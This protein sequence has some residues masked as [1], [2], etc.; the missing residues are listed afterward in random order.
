MKFGNK[1]GFIQKLCVF[2]VHTTI[3]WLCLSCRN[4]LFCLGKPICLFDPDA[5]EH[6][7]VVQGRNG[8]FFSSLVVVLKLPQPG[9]HTAPLR[10][11]GVQW[12]WP[13]GRSSHPLVTRWHL[14]VPHS[15]CGNSF[16]QVPIWTCRRAAPAGITRIEGEGSSRRPEG[17]NCP[18]QAFL[19]LPSQ[20]AGALPAHTDLCF[21]TGYRFV[22]VLLVSTEVASGIGCLRNPSMCH[23]VHR[24]PNGCAGSHMPILALPR[25]LFFFPKILA[26]PTS[27][28]AALGGTWPLHAANTGPH[29]AAHS[30]GFQEAAREFLT[31]ER[32]HLKSYFHYTSNT[33]SL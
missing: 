28:V 3:T 10:E 15:K 4:L 11:I 24:C 25:K 33:C 9:P 6:G 30:S 12:W 31:L 26:R 16:A 29:A 17:P 18:L 22:P 19:Q 5:W 1:T 21:L 8:H 2:L 14:E 32:I 23:R 27:Q 20:H 13:T 7:R